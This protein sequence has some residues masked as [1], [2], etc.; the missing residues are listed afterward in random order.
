MKSITSVELSLRRLVSGKVREVFDLED[1]L[2]FVATDRISAFD[3]VMPQG[4][5]EK[6]RVLTGM[7]LYWFDLVSD[8]CPNHLIS[9][10]A[11]ELPEEAAG[12]ISDL[13]GR[14]MIVK[15][16]QMLPVEFV[17]RGYLAGSGWK[18]Y[19]KTGSVCGVALPAGLKEADRLPEPIFTPATKATTGHDENITEEHA[20][21]LCGADVLKRAKQSAINIYERAAGVAAERG[22]ILADTKFEFGLDS[23]GDSDGD[24]DAGSDGEVTLADEVLTPDSSRFWPADSWEPG[25]SPPSF[26]KQYLRDWLDDAG[27]DHEPPP[28][29]LPDE[30]VEQTK[31]RY[32]E[33]YERVTEEPFDA[34]LDRISH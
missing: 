24:S 1:T 17:V 23:D 26:D 2:L 25:S 13:S 7:S 12:H 33:A 16:L 11:G 19:K 10:S 30:V 6:G 8:I 22:I 15:K 29:D 18:D 31:K 20:A 9:A 34:Y 27:W 4:I 28:P 14:F 32:V 21:A 5:P 3:V